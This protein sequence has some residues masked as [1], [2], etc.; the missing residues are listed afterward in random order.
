M[1]LQLSW[2]LHQQMADNI[3]C[4]CVPFG[5]SQVTSGL[6]SVPSE[7]MEVHIRYRLQQGDGEMIGR[8]VRGGGKEGEKELEI[9]KAK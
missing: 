3:P 9:E 1:L 7:Q 6:A 5:K 8:S 2:F 4:V